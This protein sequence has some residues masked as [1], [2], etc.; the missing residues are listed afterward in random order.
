[1]SRPSTD[2][3][4]RN[5]PNQKSIY[6]CQIKIENSFFKPQPNSR[7]KKRDKLSPKD[8]KDWIT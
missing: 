5:K 7:K 3:Q 2:D 8:S 1:M 4:P 6:L